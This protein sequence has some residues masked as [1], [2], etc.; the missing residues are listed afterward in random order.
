LKERENE[1]KD[2]H[3][4]KGVSRERKFEGALLSVIFTQTANWGFETF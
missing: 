4:L 1:E 2:W 3:M